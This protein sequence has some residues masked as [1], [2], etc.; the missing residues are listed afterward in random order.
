[1][2]NFVVIQAELLIKLNKC[3]KVTYKKYDLWQKKVTVC[4]LFLN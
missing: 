3:G 4:V 2:L 1:M